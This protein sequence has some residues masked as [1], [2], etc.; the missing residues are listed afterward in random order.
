M[1]QKL[2]DKASLVMIPSQYKE[3]K[4]YNIKPEDQSSSF[5]FERGSAATRVNSS[6]LIEYVGVGAELITDGGFDDASA[7]STFGGANVSG[8]K[9]ILDAQNEVAQQYNLGIVSGKEY[10]VDFTIEGENTHLIVYLGSN[11]SSNADSVYTTQSEGT[12][13]IRLDAHT[14]GDFIKFN[15]PS[16]GKNFTVDNVSVRLIENDTPRLDYSGTEPALL[17]EPQRTNL[18]A[19]SEYITPTT[20]AGSS[21]DYNQGISPNGTNNATKITRGTNNLIARFNNVVETGKTYT[22]SMY[23]KT[24]SGTQ[25]IRLDITDEAIGDFTATTDWK[26]FSVTGT[27]TRTP[28]STY[29]FVDFNFLNAQEGDSVLIYAPQIEEGSYATSYIPTNGQA[30]TRLADV[31]QGGGDSTIFNDSEGVLYANI[32]ALVDD[33]SDRKIAIV[34]GATQNQVSIGYSISSKKIRAITYDGAVKGETFTNACNVLDFNKIAYKYKNLDNQLWVN[35]FLLDTSNNTNILNGVTLDNLGFDANAS[36]FY[37]TT[38]EVI[39]FNEAL[40]DTELEALTSYDSFTE[41]ATEQLYT[42]E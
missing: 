20:V 10:K 13:S 4:I 7:W 36:D 28:Q 40:S 3:G 30:E 26:R 38:K 21:L 5:E 8:G 25:D 17:L 31:C 41:M 6:G 12:Y 19:N 14:D 9:L 32:A 23:V 35:G 24:L 16:S 33:N 42:I 11:S 29:H 2:F 1:A 15:C 27:V 37:G 22:F 39:A 34:E 18:I